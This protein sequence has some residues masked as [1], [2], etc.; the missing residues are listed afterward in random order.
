MQIMVTA[1]TWQIW[2]ITHDAVY[3]GYV[4]LA[5]FL[6]VLLLVIPA[7]HVADHYDRKIILASCM[8]LEALAALGLLLFSLGDQSVV[9]PVAHLRWWHCSL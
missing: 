7:G 4:G 3:L 5:V 9:W 8:A 6:P 1:L 2:S